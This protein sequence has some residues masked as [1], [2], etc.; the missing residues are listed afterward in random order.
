MASSTPPPSNTT[1]LIAAPDAV[2][3]I[4]PRTKPGITTS[5]RREQ[6]RS[7]ELDRRTRRSLPDTTSYETWD[8]DFGSPGTGPKVN[9]VH[10]RDFANHDSLTTYDLNGRVISRHVDAGTPLPSGAIRGVAFTY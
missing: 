1:N 9:S 3:R 7:D 4:L 2:C 10:H 8:Y 5:A 6:A